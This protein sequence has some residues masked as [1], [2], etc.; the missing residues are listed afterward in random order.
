MRS[1][2]GWTSLIR[3]DEA[4]WRICGISIVALALLAF[5]MLAQAQT[6]VSQAPAAYLPNFAQIATYVFVMLGPV[7]VLGP[8]AVMTGGME[9]PA[10]RKL[11]LI[12]V[13]VSL[14]A[15]AAA[16]T[17]GVST[18][19]KWVISPGALQMTGGII[20]FLVALKPILAQFAPPVAPAVTTV[21]AGDKPPQPSLLKLALSGLVFP[22]IVTPQG[23]ALVILVVAAYPVLKGQM[24]LAVVQIMAINLVVMLCARL[25]LKTPGISFAL[26]VFGNVLGVLQVA[27][28]IQLVIGA[29]RL[30]HV[31]APA[32]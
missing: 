11:A 9:K 8:F 17:I 18:L 3:T 1:R 28:G 24:V 6:P 15:L 31:L 30:L 25:I 5:P 14:L 29:L 26:T 12:G 22:T 10:L 21:E 13:L 4:A 19:E 27:L 20:I 23:L 7:K 2:I 32:V 16:A